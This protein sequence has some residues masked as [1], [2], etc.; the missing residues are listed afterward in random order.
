MKSAIL[1]FPIQLMTRAVTAGGTAGKLV[2][3]GTAIAHVTNSWV[4]AFGENTTQSLQDD[5][6]KDPND[7]GTRLSE[8]ASNLVTFMDMN[9][10]VV[11]MNEE[12]RLARIDV[13]GRQGDYIQDLGGKSV[14]YHLEG[15][16]YGV[17]PNEGQQQSPFSPIF[18]ATFDNVAVGQIKLLQMLQRSGVPTPF[19]CEYG[20][21]EVIIRR[22]EVEQIGGKP[23]YIRYSLDLL[24]YRRLPLIAKMGAMAA[25]GV[26]NK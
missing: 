3:T 1:G 23:A 17:D 5:A 15:N 25:L 24:E 2:A 9:A 7:L 21:A 22:L 10:E 16:F 18:K 8:F 13:P 12:K 20:I 4:R 14:E 6:N 19:I 11:R 26:T